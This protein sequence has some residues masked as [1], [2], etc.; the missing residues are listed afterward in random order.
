M[1]VYLHK[2][3]VQPF[4]QEGPFTYVSC[5][6]FIWKWRDLQFK[7]DTERQIIYILHW[8]NIYTYNLYCVIKFYLLKFLR[9]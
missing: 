9:A 5:V 7:V 6:S 1:Y 8:D 2:W 3:L 4:S